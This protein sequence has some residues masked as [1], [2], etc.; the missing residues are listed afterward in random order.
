M[1]LRPILGLALLLAAQPAQAGDGFLDA[2]FGGR[3]G[4]TPPNPF[5]SN[6]PSAPPSPA[7]VRAERERRAARRERGEAGPVP[8]GR[9]PE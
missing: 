8:P 1:P 9:I 4:A 5:A 7:D 6:Y 3:S 2:L